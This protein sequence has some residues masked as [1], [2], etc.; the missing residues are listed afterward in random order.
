[1]AET[2]AFNCLEANTAWVL[3]GRQA[4]AGATRATGAGLWATAVATVLLRS[5][6]CIGA[7]IGL[8]GCVIAVGLPAAQAAVD[9]IA[10]V[11]A[12][13]TGQW[14]DVGRIGAIT[15]ASHATEECTV[16]AIAVAA[17]S[18]IAAIM[19]VATTEETG[20]T[21]IARE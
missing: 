3:A 18:A 6:V 4:G 5:V 21:V 8:H 19:G 15:G 12:K 9:P 10:V 2:P 7:D 14:H 20:G 17:T 16:T 11:T 1:M 13:P